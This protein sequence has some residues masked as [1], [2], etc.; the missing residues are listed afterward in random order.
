MSFLS[1]KV[2]ISM[3]NQFQWWS[4]ITYLMFGL[5]IG[6]LLLSSI[7]IYNYTFRTLEDAHTI[8]L[9]NT[10]TVVNNVNLDMYKR[11][12]DAIKLKSTRS[13]IDRNL[14]NIFVFNTSSPAVV[15]ASP[16][17]TTSPVSGY[18]STT[19]QQ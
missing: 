17:T 19:S 9:L 10:D 14:R 3:K 12:V 11:A 2:K 15:P 6:S 18:V 8:V 7:I 16:I 5:M 1:Q 13:E 4:I